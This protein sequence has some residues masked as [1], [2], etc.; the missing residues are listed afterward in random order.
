MVPGI[1]PFD[2]F[3]FG[4][5]ALIVSTESVLLTIFVLISQNRL[6]RQS[7]HRAHLE[8]QISLLAEQESTKTLQIVQAIAANMGMHEHAQDEKAREL[9]QDTHIEKLAQ[10][11]KQQLPD[12]AQP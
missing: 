8:L 5:L 3:P 10:D 2:R 1:T 12:D 6:L 4:L 7:E 9:A 11:I